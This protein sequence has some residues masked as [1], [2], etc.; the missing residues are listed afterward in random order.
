MSNANLS[1]R[2]LAD[3]IKQVIP[4]FVVIESEFSEDK[5]KRDYLISNAKIEKT[6]FA[7]K[8]SLD[9]GIEELRKGITS[10]QLEKYSNL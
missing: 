5:D 9:D 2:E 4:N 10:L 3:K 6:G 8:F 7:P 1:K